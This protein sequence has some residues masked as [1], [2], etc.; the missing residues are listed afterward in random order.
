MD[1]LGLVIVEDKIRAILNIKFLNTIEK[2]ERYLGLIGYL[3]NYIP[4]YSIIII[5][6]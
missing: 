4:Y 2:I 6:L 1:T 3:Y 5:L